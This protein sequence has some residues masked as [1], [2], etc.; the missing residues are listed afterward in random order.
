MSTPMND[1][2]APETTTDSATA[3]CPLCG[4]VPCEFCRFLEEYRR[5][6]RAQGIRDV[7]FHGA[8]KIVEHLEDG[9][10][11]LVAWMPLRD[12]E[13][14]FSIHGSSE[15]HLWKH[16]MVLLAEPSETQPGY[17]DVVAI[18]REGLAMN[19]S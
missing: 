8:G 16:G 5:R 19:A 18:L 2:T 3:G 10:E 4:D 17:F 9:S 11:E 15:V 6:R 1:E 7:E 14:T 13:T 12:D